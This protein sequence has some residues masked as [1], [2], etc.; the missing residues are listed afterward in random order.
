MTVT[1]HPG[2]KNAVEQFKTEGKKEGDLL[3][4]DWLYGH[5]FIDRPTASM[6]H[7]DAQKAEIKFLDAFKKFEETLLFANL[8]ALENVR[9]A[10]YR[11]VPAKEQTRWAYRE[12]FREVARGMKK[13]T[14]RLVHTDL[15]KL[16][17]SE[18]IGRAHV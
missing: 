4:F 3:T 18:Q 1:L 8:I 11:V 9:G 12:G 2:W 14:Q 16:S 5:F 13:M 15:S 17:P 6:S 10:G 7:A